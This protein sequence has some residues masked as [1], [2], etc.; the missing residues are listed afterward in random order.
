MKTHFPFPGAMDA[1]PPP[2]AHDT[3]VHPA[4][5]AGDPATADAAQPEAARRFRALMAQQ[6]DAAA[7]ARQQDDI[8]PDS[9]TEGD[10]RHTAADALPPQARP[11]RD[12]SVESVERADDVDASDPF[13]ARDAETA[14]AADD[15][16]G[17][18]G[19]ARQDT[20]GDASADNAATFAPGDDAVT[21][22]R[23][24]GA[25][26]TSPLS[27]APS[28]PAA[29]SHGPTGTGAGTFATALDR[30]ARSSSRT[31]PASGVG[32][33]TSQR[34]RH[35]TEES[36]DPGTERAETL[37]RLVAHTLA[38]QAPVHSEKADGDIGASDHT[39]GTAISIRIDHVFP[40]TLLTLTISES[41][42]SLRFESGSA[43]SRALLFDQRHAL[44]SRVTKRTGRPTHIDIV[45]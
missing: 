24:W 44:S 35:A 45:A 6:Q 40:E 14:N 13:G 29:L 38:E 1:S 34:L 22:K 7:A 43:E 32:G 3:P 12:E 10:K 21:D 41:S 5:K 17:A 18:N 28:L 31:R 4:A 30:R 9:A 20:A 39:L 25:R 36:D 15:A 42:L 19:S 2:P 16:I 11:K 27:A 33:T 23:S 26:A 8:A 37:S